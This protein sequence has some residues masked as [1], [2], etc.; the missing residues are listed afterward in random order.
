MPKALAL[1]AIV[2][3]LFARPVKAEEPFRQLRAKEI[4]TRIVGSEL[5]DGV[6]WS[7]YY[8]PDSVVVSVGMGKRRLGSWT[9]EGDKLCSTSRNDRP[10]ECYEVWAAGKNISLRHEADM[11]IMD[12]VIEPHTRP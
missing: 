5:T 3:T 1:A 11:P 4:R 10:V 12:A 8:R 6:H 7:W 9:I 2:L